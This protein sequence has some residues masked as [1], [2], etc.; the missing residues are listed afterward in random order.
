VSAQKP[1]Q[2][3]KNRWD[4]LNASKSDIQINQENQGTGGGDEIRTHGTG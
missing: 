4:E 3:G 1:A 2:G